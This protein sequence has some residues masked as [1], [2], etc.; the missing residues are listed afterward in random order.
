MLRSA[1]LLAAAV[2]P[3]VVS[4]SCGGGASSP[5]APCLRPHRR[6]RHPR[7]QPRATERRPD[8]GRRHGLGRSR[9]LREH[10]HQDPEP[11]P[12][13]DRGRAVHGLLRAGADLRAVAG[14]AHDRPLPGPHGHP[15]EPARQAAR[16][17]G[18][19]RGGA[20][21]PRL[22]HRHGREVA[23]RLGGRGHADPPR[24][25]LLLR[26]PGGG[27]RGRLRPRGP[28]D[29]GRRGPGPARAAVHPGSA[30]V[31][32]REQGPPVLR[33]HRPPRSPPAELPR[34][35]LRG[36]LGRR[37]LRRHDR[38]A[39]RDGGRPDEGAQ[40]PGAG[41]EHPRSVHERQRPRHP[42]EGAGLRRDPS[43]A[44]RARARKAGCACPGSR[45]GPRGS[46]RGGW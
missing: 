9:E 35:R 27:G 33:L 44:P 36:P 28:A 41:P 6:R 34:G 29:E 11:R 2:L 25:R 1:S 24:L 30:Q 7:A 16:R 8:P 20:E 10:G 12:P 17:R 22:R 15:L 40:G 38:G 26:H 19:D 39:G 42:P 37:Q 32:H 13:G 18:R 45:A 23:P 46:A 14:R 31:H 43:A 5:A 4:L 3:I 21:G